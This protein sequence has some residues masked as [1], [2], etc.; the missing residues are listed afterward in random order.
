MVFDN[1]LAKAKKLKEDVLAVLGTKGFSMDA[2]P[3]S[4]RLFYDII[5]RSATSHQL[6]DWDVDQCVN[7]H[8]SW[9]SNPS[10]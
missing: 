5:V 3:A 1:S 9:V 8:W 10:N 7:N 6:K 2:T 4:T